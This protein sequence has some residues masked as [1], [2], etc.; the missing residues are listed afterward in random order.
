ME[1]EIEDYLEFITSHLEKMINTAET[2]GMADNYFVGVLTYKM[3]ESGFLSLG[4]EEM[5]KLIEL[6]RNHSH[7]PELQKYVNELIKEMDNG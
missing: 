6:A 2:V 4:E 3:V 1:Y 7:N 5:D